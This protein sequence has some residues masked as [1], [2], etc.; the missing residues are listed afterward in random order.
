MKERERNFPLPSGLES[1]LILDE[2]NLPLRIKH[3]Q[4]ADYINRVTAQRDCHMNIK[5]MWGF[6]VETSFCPNMLFG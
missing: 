1:C 2:E 4:S 3:S 5:S 6:V